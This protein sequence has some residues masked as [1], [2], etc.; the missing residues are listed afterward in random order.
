MNEHSFASG[1]PEAT[2]PC[3]IQRKSELAQPL[4]RHCR[5][6]IQEAASQVRETTARLG[7][8]QRG[9][10]AKSGTVRQSHR[11]ARIGALAVTRPEMAI[12]RKHRIVFCVD[13]LPVW[14]VRS[15]RKS[16][17]RC[18]RAVT[19]LCESGQEFKSRLRGTNL[20]GRPRKPSRL[21]TGLQLIPLWICSA[22]RRLDDG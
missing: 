21:S 19:G 4:S 1:C 15:R 9:L 22:A 10:V 16:Q 3:N 5:I 11:L 2:T 8:Q 12:S 7:F 14:G 13:V 17:R 18:W 6:A 20:I